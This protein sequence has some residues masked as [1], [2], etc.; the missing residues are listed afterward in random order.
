M[1][2][3][4][5]PEWKAF[6]KL[7]L[8]Y[9]VRS[10]AS[11]KFIS[12]ML[13]LALELV[14]QQRSWQQFALL[15]QGL[16]K[17]CKA[18]TNRKAKLMAIDCDED[19]CNCDPEPGWEE[20]HPKMEFLTIVFGETV[21]QKRDYFVSEFC[22]ALY[23][24]KHSCS[25]EVMHCAVKTALAAKNW[26]LLRTLSVT[27][28]NADKEQSAS[29][30]MHNSLV[31]ENVFACL[32]HMVTHPEDVRTSGSGEGS[33]ATV[34]ERWLMSALDDNSRFAD[35]G[36]FVYF[37]KGFFGQFKLYTDEGLVEWLFENHQPNLALLLAVTLRND[38]VMV[39]VKVLQQ[40][41]QSLHK[42]LIMDCFDCLCIDRRWSAVIAFLSVLPTSVLAPRH[43]FRVFSG[44]VGKE[45]RV[46]VQQLRS[47]LKGVGM[48]AWEMGLCLALPE[49][50]WSSVRRLLGLCEDAAMVE[51]ALKEAARCR[52][53]DIC[54]EHIKRC[55]DPETLNDVF[56]QALTNAQEANVFS[57]LT[58]AANFIDLTSER[59]LFEASQN[60]SVVKACVRV[61]LS[62]TTADIDVNATNFMSCKVGHGDL[63]MVMLLHRAG[64]W[65]CGHLSGVS[66]DEIAFRREHCYWHGDSDLDSLRDEGRLQIRDYFINVYDSP[67]SLQDL[68]R[69][70]VSRSL[71]LR[72]GRMERIQAL[73][74][75]AIIQNFLRFEDLVGDDQ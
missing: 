20:V 3:I 65:D 10:F 31:Q 50:N 55:T 1:N 26:A 32:E 24:K 52:Q 38:E 7:F 60:D 43:L 17:F 53:W 74:V 28:S 33:L 67:L 68:S 51:W 13:M 14:V 2:K 21:L 22:Q 9:S 18:A 16:L 39:M 57:I 73:P 62:T 27:Q 48:V 19:E 54:R 6:L 29:H 45:R 11:F 4:K 66:F 75:P 71:G 5:T 23:E 37:D 56:H 15:V 40:S 46:P 30:K 36:V 44:S 41:L 61:G 64:L 35:T 12:K 49:K 58:Y 42:Q 34:C 70:V 25:N 8:Q 72:P 47:K 63:H 69:L 59:E